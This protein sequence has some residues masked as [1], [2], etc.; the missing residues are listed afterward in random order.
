[1]RIIGICFKTVPLILFSIWN[2]DVSVTV[3]TVD[4]RKYQVSQ[5]AQWLH[6]TFELMSWVIFTELLCP[7][8]V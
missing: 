7:D 8:A 2:P 5:L 6:V 3:S 1:M 4:C